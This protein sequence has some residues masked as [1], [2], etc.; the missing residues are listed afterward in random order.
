[1]KILCIG[2][3]V[4]DIAIK[5]LDLEDFDNGRAAVD[6]F[7]VLGGGD[8]NNAA[9]DLARLGD[10][11]R[12]FGKI[13][14]DF[15]GDRIV[16]L[17]HENHVDTSYIRRVSEPTTVSILI[18]GQNGDPTL[19]VIR[20]GANETMNADDVTEDM[21]LWADHVHMVSV[22]NLHAFDGAGTARVFEL[23]HKM[24]KTTSMDLKAKI[25]PLEN[26]LAL[27]EKTLYNCDVFLPSDYEVEYLCGI[28][29][30]EKAAEFF[31]PFGI[32]VFGC[33]CGARGVYLT[34]YHDAFMLPSLYSGTPV[35]VIGAGDAFSATFAS[36]WKRGYDLR[37]C[38]TL[39]SAAS[40]LV[41]GEVGSTT[42]M[43]DL[44]AVIDY[45]TTHG[46]F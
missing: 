19:S 34:D 17:F 20:H 40:A 6:S 1:M 15:L 4:T 37:A 28:T 23:A 42:G 30:P 45:A 8:C 10:E 43:R 38:G 3:I 26:R 7:E 11:V 36:V 32:R 39:A 31:H 22:L 13:G 5:S 21:I 9:I 27:I 46:S 35:D 29:D 12:P 33:K 16:D 41:L 44:D 14:S 2:P 18:L 24:G 25:A